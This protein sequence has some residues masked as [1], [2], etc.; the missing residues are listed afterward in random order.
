MLGDFAV[1]AKE[2]TMID[3]GTGLRCAG[4][5]LLFLALA[6]G[7]ASSGASKAQPAPGPSGGIAAPATYSGRLPWP[8]AECPG[9]DIT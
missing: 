4:L 8:C 1:G 3:L 6:A 5:I 2:A 9:T 7:C